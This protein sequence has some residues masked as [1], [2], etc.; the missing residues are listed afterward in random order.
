MK[1]LEIKIKKK[2]NEFI[3]EIDDGHLIISFNDI[4]LKGLWKRISRF[5]Y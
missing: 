5:I 4:T 3:A 2:D 1:L